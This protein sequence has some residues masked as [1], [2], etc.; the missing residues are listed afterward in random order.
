MA[1]KRLLHEALNIHTIN[2]GML[3]KQVREINALQINNSG[4]FGIKCHTSVNEPYFYETSYKY[5]T[6]ANKQG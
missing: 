6:L 2:A 1:A 5:N 4:D 3:L